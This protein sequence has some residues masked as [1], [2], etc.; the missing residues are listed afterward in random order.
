MAVKRFER[1]DKAIVWVKGRVATMLSESNYR[2]SSV[3]I[4]LEKIL[5]E[6]VASVS[7]SYNE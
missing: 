2:G 5:D 1:K 7:A 4:R 3:K 6:W